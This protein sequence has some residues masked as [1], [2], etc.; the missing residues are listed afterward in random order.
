MNGEFSLLVILGGTHRQVG[1]IEL[2]TVMTFLTIHPM[3]PKNDE[4]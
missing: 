3:K 2:R 1:Y 4:E